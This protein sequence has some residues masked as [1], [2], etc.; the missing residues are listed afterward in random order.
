MASSI[1]EPLTRK[2]GRKEKS[3]VEMKKSWSLPHN[4]EKGGKSASSRRPRK[5]RRGIAAGGTTQL[6][7]EAAAKPNGRSGSGNRGGGK[8]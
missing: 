1:H 2:R 3:R 8:K 6:E 4:Q 7:R 5:E